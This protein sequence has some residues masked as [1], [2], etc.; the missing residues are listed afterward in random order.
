MKTN[1][2]ITIQRGHTG[3]GTVKRL[4]ENYVE[5]V[6]G[7]LEFP[8]SVGALYDLESAAAIIERSVPFNRRI[9]D[10]YLNGEMGH[11]V[12]RECKDYSDYVRRIHTIDERN[13]AINIRRVWINRNYVGPNGV[14]CIAIMGEVAPF[15]PHASSIERALNNPH[16][17]L[18]FSIRSMTT[19]RIVAGCRRKFFDNIIT[20]DVVN[21]P[22]L[23]V[24]NKFNAPSCES[25]DLITLSSIPVTQTLMESVRATAIEQGISM[26]SATGIALE[27]SLNAFDRTYGRHVASARN[28]LEQW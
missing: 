7:A 3:K 26:E 16:A 25:A 8:N 1:F 4:D 17:N 27:S 28:F 14:K 21:E 11:P 12:E 24:A 20:W 13:T 2:E 10:G 19:D 23:S 22:G 18:A 9:S 5:V 15:G 6:L